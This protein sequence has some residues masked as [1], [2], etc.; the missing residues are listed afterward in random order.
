MVRARLGAFSTLLALLRIDVAPL[1]SR[2]AGVKFARR[3]A[4][5]SETVLAVIC[6]DVCGDR[7]VLTGCMEDLDD[8]PVI[9]RPWSLSAGEPYSFPDD[10]TLFVDTAPESRLRSRY[11][12]LRKEVLFFLQSSIKSHLRDSSQHVVFYLY[13]TFVSIH[14]QSPYLKHTFSTIILPYIKILCCIF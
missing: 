6:H 7:A 4:G 8:I 14:S 11:Q 5:F 2:M 12:L 9:L 10:L 1:V 13:N 3:N